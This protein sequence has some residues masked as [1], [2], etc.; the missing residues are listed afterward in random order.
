MNK[1]IFDKVDP[2]Y[3]DCMNGMCEHVEHKANAM[4]WLLAAVAIAITA[5]KYIYDTRRN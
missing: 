2:K 4:W 1:T 3:L 5:G